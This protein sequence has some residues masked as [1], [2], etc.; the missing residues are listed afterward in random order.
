MILCRFNCECLIKQAEGVNEQLKSTD[1][2]KWGAGLRWR[3]LPE[4][5]APTEA[6]A[7]TGLMNNIRN[8]AEEIVLQEVIFV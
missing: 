4:A 8:R 7:E 3:P 2:M 5:E 6:A 1:Q